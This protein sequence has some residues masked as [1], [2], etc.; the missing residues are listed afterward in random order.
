QVVLRCVDGDPVEPGIECT[1]TTEQLQCPISLDERFLG[2]ILYFVR[3]FHKAG[4]KRSHLVLITQYQKIE[5]LLLSIQHPIHE[6]LIC[7][8][9]HRHRLRT[10]EQF[11]LV[12]PAM[13]TRFMTG[14]YREGTRNIV[15]VKG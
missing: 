3:I 10:M 12:K 4:N 11:S 15:D 1:V 9:L 13:T 6:L 14:R 2:N 7:I 8:V 5:S